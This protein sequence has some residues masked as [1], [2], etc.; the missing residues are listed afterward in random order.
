M[1]IPEEAIGIYD[2]SYAPYALGDV[3]TWQVNLMCEAYERKATHVS[4]ILIAD[5]YVPSNAFQKHI[6]SVN[7]K[8]YLNNLLDA[9]LCTNPLD[10]IKI[11]NCRYAFNDF[12]A[13]KTT[14]AAWPT[15][16][17]H[18]KKCL[19]YS[20]HKKVNRFYREH[21]FVPE[22]QIPLGYKDWVQQFFKD[23][24]SQKYV[25]CVN[26][27]QARLKK[28]P[29]SL[30]RDSSA[31]VWFDFM[32]YIHKINQD[33]VFVLVGGYEEIEDRFSSLPNV[34]V[35]REIGLNLAHE[36]AI[37]KTS[38]LFMGT[39]SG[40]AAMATFSGTP[41]VITNYDPNAAPETEIEIGAKQYPFAKKNQILDWGTEKLETL[42][43][44]FLEIYNA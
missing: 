40:F 23:H 36:L 38:N 37:L 21:G 27:R 5:Q 1:S 12:L 41:Y 15:F 19:D 18:L 8:F 33:V 20:S 24:F 25:V 17:G 29:Q 16:D 13:L 32:Q 7:Y 31:D 42:T 4:S 11:F 43:T 35:V 3:L 14:K 28:E 34:I 10:S 22:L 39:S 2:F 44:L 26:I 6:T 30:Y 9:F